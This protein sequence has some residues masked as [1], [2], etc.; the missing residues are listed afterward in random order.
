MAVQ[1][2][3]PSPWFAHKWAGPALV[4]LDEANGLKFVALQRTL[5]VTQRALRATLDH[6]LDHGYVA[7]NPGHGHPLRPEYLV[8][9]EGRRWARRYRALWR[10][11]L[12]HRV[13]SVLLLRWAL[14]VLNALDEDSRRYSELRATLRPATDRAL[15][16]TLRQLVWAGLVARTVGEDYPPATFYALTELGQHFRE[17]VKDALG[18]GQRDRG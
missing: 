2:R 17:A 7:R 10:L 4:E 5:N 13:Q 6:L 12:A 9:P 11:A 14:P 3:P 15:S 18:G 8:T 16:A 1:T